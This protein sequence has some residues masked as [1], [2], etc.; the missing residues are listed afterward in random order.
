MKY[1]DLIQNL[2]D[3]QLIQKKTP[4]PDSY[5]DKNYREVKSFEKK[6]YD[7]KASFFKIICDR[8]SI[9]KVNKNDLYSLN[10]NRNACMRNVNK[11]KRLKIKLIRIIKKQLKKDQKKNKRI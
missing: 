2:K 3:L 1:Q 11:I 9:F 6:Y 8:K 7:N 4:G 10:F 5:S